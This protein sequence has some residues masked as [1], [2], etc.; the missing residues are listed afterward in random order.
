MSVPDGFL[1][2]N[3]MNPCPVCHRPDWC[4]ISSDDPGNPSRAVCAREESSTRFGEAGWLHQLRDDYFPSLRRRPRTV[5]V[6]VAAREF[7]RLALRSRLPLGTAR[8]DYLAQGL[9]LKSE[10]LHRLQ[11]GWAEQGQILETGTKCQ[12]NGAWTFPMKTPGGGV[13]GIRLRAPSGFKYSVAGGKQGLF[14]PE[15]LADGD[16]TLF[17]AEGPTDTAALLDLGFR[18]V[19]RPSCS[20]GCL[21]LKAMVRELGGL[22]VVVVADPDSPGLRGADALARLLVPYC[23]TVRVI[24]PPAVF[25]DVRDWKKAGATHREIQ[26]MVAEAEP[27]AL[28]VQWTP[29][30]GGTASA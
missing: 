16:G 2:V 15:N 22:D 13:T 1:R 7:G 10:S 24:A 30:H 4:L 27:Y 17:I 18:A 28:S 5:P 26:R 11:I 3:R 14:I 29:R 21:Q 8:L 19:G 9:G 20:G 25:Q 12:G 23:R 6:S